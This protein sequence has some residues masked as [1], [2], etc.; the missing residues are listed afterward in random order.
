MYESRCFTAP[1]RTLFGEL[2]RHRRCF[3]RVRTK[4][5]SK[6]FRWP[7]RTKNTK[8]AKSF[9]LVFCTKQKWRCR[10][11][12]ELGTTAGLSIRYPSFTP[13][14]LIPTLS[15]PQNIYLYHTSLILV[16]VV[17]C[18]SNEVLAF[19]RLGLGLE[20]DWWRGVSVFWF[21]PLKVLCSSSLVWSFRQLY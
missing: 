16:F 14:L 17:L 5:I 4:K 3:D 9:F 18:F 13:G 11:S 15:P 20:G 2:N 19:R 6:T 8:R 12:N 1:P 21:R 10:D 7:A